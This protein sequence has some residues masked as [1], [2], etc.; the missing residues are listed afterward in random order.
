MHPRRFIAL[1]IALHLLQCDAAAQPRKIV[2]DCDPGID[3]AIAI[4]LAMQHSGFEIVGISTMFGNAAVD[5]TTRNALTVVELSGR[6]VPVYQGAAR[7][8]RLPMSPPPDFVHGTDGLGNTDQPLPKRAAQ[9]TAAA[10][11]LVDIAR[12]LPGADHARG[13]RAGSR[14]SQK[15]SGSIRASRRTSGR[16]L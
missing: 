3:D 7:P 11:F 13:G 9:P 4:A 14:T 12:S 6:A 15:P 16:S 5:R 2:I 8:L 1:L 10:R